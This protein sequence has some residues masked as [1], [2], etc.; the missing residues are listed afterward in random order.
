VRIAKHVV[1]SGWEDVV[2]AS[3]RKGEANPPAMASVR[4]RAALVR[5]FIVDIIPFLPRLVLDFAAKW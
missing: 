3:A 5:F 2:D 4:A 1:R